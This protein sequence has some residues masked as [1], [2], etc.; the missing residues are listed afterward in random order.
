MDNPIPVIPFLTLRFNLASL[1]QA[2]LPS[3]K[4]SML[5][6]AF[7]HAL[8]AT[9]CTM[10]ASQSCRDCLL[11]NRCAYTQIFEPFI[12]GKAPRFL[13]GLDTPPRPFTLWCDSND[14]KFA[15]DQRLKFH[16]T[17]FGTACEW[18]PYVVYAVHRMAERGLSAH[19][20]RFRLDSVEM[21]NSPGSDSEWSRIYDGNN[22]QLARA[23]AQRYVADLDIKDSVTL[24]FLSPT[25]FKS[26]N[27]LLMEF[28][29]HT[30]IFKMFRR[31]LEIAHF[32]APNG[33][34]DWDMEY[35]AAAKHIEITRRDLTW[36]D[37]RRH[38][39]RQKADMKLGGFTG[40]LHCQ[41]DLAHYSDL[42]Q[43][44]QIL[45]VGKGTTFGLGRMAIVKV[46]NRKF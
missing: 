39:N 29:F 17:L 2:F 10:P 34:V 9:V 13:R 18:V 30:L 1:G 14:R 38:S 16:M 5:R 21:A 33:R 35:L 8:K 37:W 15:K 7:G 23:E 11:C 40:I 6:G 12:Q 20:H 24:E 46:N 28:D 41:G 45:S 31:A 42:L 25:R 44:S 43:V 22:G 27:Q 36:N 26:R 32:Y 4:G 3:F 19:R